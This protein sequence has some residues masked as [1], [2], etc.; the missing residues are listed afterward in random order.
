MNAILVPVRNCLS[1]TR[2]AVRTFRAQDVPVSI[3]V[4]DNASSDGTGAWL[5]SQHDL[6]RAHFNPPKSVAASWNL[7]LRWFFQHKAEHVLVVNNDVLL[8][9]DTYRELLAANLPFATGVGVATVEQMNETYV[10]ADRERPDFSCFLIRRECWERLGPFDES[11]EGAFYED[12][13]WHVRAWR[14]GVHLTCVGLPFWHAASATVKNAP[15]P[16]AQ[17]IAAKAE[18]NRARF[19]AEFGC[20]TG[21]PEYDALF[22]PEAFGRGL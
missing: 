4:L 19:R 8:R 16:V 15:L 12:N 17:D 2:D 22:S 20:G 3:L 9:P 14:R 18:R 6:A 1:Y 10:R 5:Q 11:Y 13:A 7:G 21:A